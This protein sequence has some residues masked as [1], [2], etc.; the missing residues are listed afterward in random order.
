LYFGEPDR[1]VAVWESKTIMLM[2]ASTE[3]VKTTWINLLVKY[4]YGVNVEDPF[5]LKLVDKE[6]HP[7]TPTAVNRRKK[8]QPTTSAT[9]MNSAFRSP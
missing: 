7:S 4:V 6:D 2:G 1:L 5:R 9:K 8:S 3:S